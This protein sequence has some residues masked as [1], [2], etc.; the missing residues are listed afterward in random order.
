MNVSL[1]ILVIKSTSFWQIAFIF[2]I[3]WYW[4]FM[5][6][7]KCSHLTLGFNLLY[8]T[9]TS[10]GIYDGL[11]LSSTLHCWKEILVLRTHNSCK[12]TGI[13]KVKSASCKSAA[14]GKVVW[15]M[16][17]W[18]TKFVSSKVAG[19]GWATSFSWKGARVGKVK[20]G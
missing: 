5:S 18:C 1:I 3:C 4:S 17:G 6:I 2:L 11:L 16:V 20:F 12:G 10:F 9:F 15:L 7:L 8:R 14:M 19:I 13:G